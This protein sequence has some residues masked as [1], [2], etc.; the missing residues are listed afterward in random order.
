VLKVNNWTPLAAVL[1]GRPHKS[2]NV[3][4]SRTA[5]VVEYGKL[6]DGVNVRV[7]P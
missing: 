1:S 4:V 3:F 2:C 6:V 5:S 7:L